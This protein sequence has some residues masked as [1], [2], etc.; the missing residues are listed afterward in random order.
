VFGGVPTDSRVARVMLEA[1]YKMKL[2]GIDKLDGGEIPSYFDLLDAKTIQQNPPT[3]D[4]MRWWLTMQYDAVLHSPDQT[5]FE[6]RGSSVRCQSENERVTA[7]G[8]R[9]HTGQADPTNQ[10]FADQFTAGYA[11]LAER[12]P[13]FADLQNVFDLALVA[14][15]IRHEGL[16]SYPAGYG[17]FAADGRYAPARYVP[18]TTVESAVNHKVYNGRDVSVQVAGGVQA[19]LASVLK[20]QQVYRVAERLGSLAEH[21][22]VPTLPDGRWWWDAK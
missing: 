7:T 19:D 10:A 20:D 21:T 5:V 8:E 1:D 15:L 13:V 6:I 16:W 22:Q 18:P 11:R 2:V 14:A 17:V 12:E 4:A 3:L 9:I